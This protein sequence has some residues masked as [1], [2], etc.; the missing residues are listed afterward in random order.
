MTR[1]SFLRASRFRTSIVAAFAL[2]ATSLASLATPPQAASAAE[3][4]YVQLSVAHRAACAVSSTGVGVC[5]GR[6][7]NQYLFPNMPNGPIS[8]PTQVALPNGEIFSTIDAGENNTVCARAVS[9][10]AYCWGDHHI[11]SF[12]TSTSR[13]PVQVEFPNDMRVTNVQ[14]GYANGCALDPDQYLWCWGD[15][16]TLGDGNTEPI[17][18]PTRV[19]MPDGGKVVQYDMGPDNTCVVTHLEHLYCWGSNGDGQLGLGYAHNIPYNT[20][21]TPTLISPPTGVT[22]ASVSAG[23]HRICALSTTGTGYCWGDNYEGSFGNNT[24]TDSLRP[25]AMIVPDNESLVHISTSWYHTCV[26]TISNKTWCFGNG[27]FGELGSGTTMGGKTYRAPYVPAGTQLHSVNTGLAATCALDSENHIW[28]WG[29][30]NWRPSEQVYSALFPAT[31]PAIGSPNVG[32]LVTNSVDTTTA[33]VQANVS[34]LGFSTTTR[35][36][37]DDDPN[38][39][40]S[41]TTASNGSIPANTT[42]A[43]PISINISGLLPRTIY[44]YRFIATN[45]YGATTSTASSFTTLGEEPTTTAIR[46]SDITGNEINASFEVNPGRLETSISFE[47]ANDANFS[48]DRA[49]IQLTEASGAFGVTRSVSLTNL[50]PQQMYY[51]RVIATNQLGTTIGTTQTVT[52]VG[53][54]PTAALISSAATSRTVTINST[55]TTGLTQGSVVAQASVSD[56]FGTTIDSAASPFAS[57]GP[58]Q[59]ELTINNLSPNTSYFIRLVANN[60]LGTATSTSVSQRT[61]PGLP[62]ISN[63]IINPGFTNASVINQFDTDGY[64][65]F[66]KMLVSENSNMD[67]PTEYFVFSGVS[68]STQTVATTIN[69]LLTNREYFVVVQA[70]NENGNV[71][72]S[73]ESFSTLEPIGVLINDGASSTNTATVK[74]TFSAPLGTSAIRISN[75]SDFSNA[76]VI[77]P[78]RFL[79]WQLQASEESS[80]ERTIWVQYLFNDGSFELYSDSITLVANSDPSIAVSSDLESGTGFAPLTEP[81]RILD[82]RGG[83]RFGTTS[84]NGNAV[85]RIKITGANTT[86]NKPTGLP[87]TGIGAVALNITAVNGVTDKGYGFVNVYPCA[88]INTPPP[89]SSNLNFTDGM[90]VPNAVLAPLSNDGHICVSINGNADLLVDVAGYFPTGTGFAPLTEPKRIL[91]TRGGQRFGT[92]ST[93]GNAVTRIKI[94]G[95]NTTD[96]KPTGL[97]N[98]GIGAVA[99]NI[100]AVNGVTDKGYGFIKVY[101][102]GS[103]S[104]MAPEASNLNFAD[105]DTLPN[106][107]IAQLSSDG[108]ICVSVYGNS[109]VLVDVSGFFPT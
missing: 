29:G 47:Y 77:A 103:K 71:E 81:K 101:P 107:V 50:A 15:A 89:N 90:T 39:G 96:N 88:S 31:I 25:S 46:F 80:V 32:N 17:G 63:P 75:S 93:N 82:T 86:D 30:P 51:T 79:K 48:T 5:W 59:H 16:L 65:T 105:G 94:T 2:A 21:H 12:F 8:T 99:L 98:T 100:T 102:C 34:A 85:T 57:S 6:N 72:T 87:N 62:I 60:D 64:S 19:P 69:N 18:I 95:A 9:G 13:V 78:T 40:S 52:T 22:F 56:D 43:I 66:I 70:H 91:D 3:F 73:P 104:S 84:T 37:Y 11:G 28:C 14:S 44:H 92:T 108:Y 54:V 42:A 45:T 53:S 24:Y 76:R 7:S 20:P 49:I 27:G 106:A 74:L 67:D 33:Q 61:G 97:P 23:L 68:Q 10:R 38:F 41:T 55:I 4:S 109:D 58:T 83:Q 1:P 35:V 36:E 26:Q